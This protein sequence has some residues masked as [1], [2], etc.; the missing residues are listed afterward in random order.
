MS[1]GTKAG[2]RRALPWLRKAAASGDAWAAFV[3]GYIHD[4]ALLARRNARSAAAWYERSVS[5]GFPRAEVRLG[6]IL[7]H[8]RGDRRDLRRAILLYRA[9]HRAAGRAAHRAED[10]GSR[11]CAAY[12]LGLYYETGRG[13]RMNLAQAQRWYQRAADLGDRDAR[14][15]VRLVMEMR[16]PNRMKGAKR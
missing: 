3:L 4:E 10:R 5:Q 9:A 8:R 6:I 2:F 15:K 11:S 14:G 1:P 13:V 16:G 7:A 12:N